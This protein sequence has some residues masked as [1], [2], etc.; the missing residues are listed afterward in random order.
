V[1]QL[2]RKAGYPRFTDKKELVMCH[3][4]VPSKAL[5]QALALALAQAQA[6][7]QAQAKIE[8]QVHGFDMV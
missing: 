3:I 4:I 6:Q 5:A 8:A 2:Y 7:A 1:L